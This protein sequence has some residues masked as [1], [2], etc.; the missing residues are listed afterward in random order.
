M[1]RTEKYFLGPGLLSDIRQAILRVDAIAPSTS[2]AVSDVL[3]DRLPD[4]SGGTPIRVCTFTGS[5]NINQ[6]KTVTFQGVTTTPNTV[7]ATN[8]LFTI[9]DA[10]TSQVAYIGKVKSTEPSGAVADWHLLNVQHHETS[11]IVSVTLTTAA[12]EFTRRLTWIPYPGETA[13]LSIALSTDTACSTP[14]S[15]GSTYSGGA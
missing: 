11:V 8:Q 2:G 7:V 13:T 5:W 10:C 1:A 9:G 15:G 6:V 14:Y 12:M 3:L 4:R